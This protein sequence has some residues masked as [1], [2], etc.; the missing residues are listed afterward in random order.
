M[1]VVTVSGRCIP[2]EPGALESALSGRINDFT[3]SFLERC[4][5]PTL[6]E[7]RAVQCL[8]CGRHGMFREAQKCALGEQ[9]S[10]RESK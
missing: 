5:H 10:A 1:G 8:P 6:T 7:P 4:S 3:E 2:E 9:V